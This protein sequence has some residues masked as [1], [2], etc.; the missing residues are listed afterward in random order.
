MEYNARRLLASQIR[1]NE[2]RIGEPLRVIIARAETTGEPITGGIQP[3]FTEGMDVSPESDI[4]TDRFEL[5]LK[6]YDNN[7][8]A[9]LSKVKAAQQRE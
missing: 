9:R 7:E 3:E 4:R 1:S 2:S 6:A 5:A 8:R